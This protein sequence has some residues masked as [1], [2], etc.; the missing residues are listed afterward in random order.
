MSG[1]DN[2]RHS[3]KRSTRSTEETGQRPITNYFRFQKGAGS[4]LA[5]V[6]CCRFAAV[7]DSCLQLKLSSSSQKQPQS[8]PASSASSVGSA[9]SSDT[10]NEE[11]DVS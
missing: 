1:L 11:F 2:Y 6:G 10:D 3:M 9:L 7:S 5:E 4:V 8:A